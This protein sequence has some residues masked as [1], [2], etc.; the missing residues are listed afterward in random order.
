MSNVVYLGELRR[1][2]MLL[3]CARNALLLE[4]PEAACDSLIRCLLILRP[5]PDFPMLLKMQKHVKLDIQNVSAQ[6]EERE[7]QYAQREREEEKK[8]LQW[9]TKEG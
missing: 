1:I 6:Q 3:G 5:M 4:Q 8:I 2:N 7:R 9:R